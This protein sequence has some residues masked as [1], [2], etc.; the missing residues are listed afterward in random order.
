MLQLA[1]KDY[2]NAEEDEEEAE[3]NVSKSWLCSVS[4]LR[5]ESITRHED[6]RRLKT[7]ASFS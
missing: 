2:K 4:Y 1:T 5:V 7:T 6:A 3:K